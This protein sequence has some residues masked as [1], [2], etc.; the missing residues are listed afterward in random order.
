MKKVILT[1]DSGIDPIIEKNMIPATIIENNEKT[2]KDSIDIDSKTILDKTKDGNIFTTASPLLSEFEDKFK[3]ILE[4]GNDGVHLC[5]S[6]GISEGSYN[7]ANLVANNLNDE[8]DNKIYVVDTLTGATG[9]TLIHEIADKLALQGY[10]SIDIV[11]YLNEL[12]KQ[13]FSSFYVPDPKGFIRSGRNKSELCSKDKAILMGIKT[14]LMA[15]IKFRVDFNEEGNLYTKSIFKSKKRD[16]M[17][18]LIKSIINQEN[19]NEYD[20]SIVT[21]G[22][23]RENYISMDDLITY[24]E[25]LHYFDKIIRKDING[26]VACYGC[27]DLCGISLIKRK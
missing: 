26:V 24:L 8:Y 27:D 12:K 22:T 15:G 21:I 1:S 3:N 14:A 9:G 6:S 16:G 2:Y 7:S 5:M 19:K 4:D 25:D 11:K 17:M 13:I 18:K 23:L 20:S 10:K